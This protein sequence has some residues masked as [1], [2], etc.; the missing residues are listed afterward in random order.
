[1][2]DPVTNVEIE[3]VLSSIRRLVSENARASV[4]AEKAP[5]KEG[6]EAETDDATASVEEDNVAPARGEAASDENMLLLLTPALRVPEAGEDGTGEETAEEAPAQEEFASAEDAEPDDAPHATFAAVVEDAVYD[7]LDEAADEIAEEAVTGTPAEEEALAGEAD[8]GEGDVAGGDDLKERIAE[9]EA[10]VA[11]QEGEWEP[12]G[13]ED[14]PYAG[15]A[16]ETLTWEDHVEEP[17]EN[18]QAHDHVWEEDRLDEP[19]QETEQVEL[20]PSTEPEPRMA[21]EVSAPTP[22]DDG[23]GP[24]DFEFATAAAT[25]GVSAADDEAD[26][27]DLFGAENEAAVIDE[28]MLREMVAEIV[29]QE[30]QGTLGERITRN[31]RKLVRREIHRALAAQELD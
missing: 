19:V 16:V 23:P 31:V 12:D 21:E 4:S 28:E 29:R 9:L 22:A 27:V 5:A 25:L 20:T 24:D 8:R 14:D 7:A 13:D 18:L 15:G 17:A 2:S 10:V 1:M 26:S 6:E 3:D 11:E 30:L